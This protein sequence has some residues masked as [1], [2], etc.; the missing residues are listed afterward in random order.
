M[1]SVGLVLSTRLGSMPFRR[2]YG[3]DLWDKEFSDMLSANKADI[4]ASLRNAISKYEKRL[5]NLTVS[6]VGDDSTGP[7]VLGMQ[8]KVSGN[9]RDGEEE[10]KFEAH[11]DLG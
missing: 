6:F 9:Y 3:C 5:Y 7:H 1:Y 10:M 2:D 4:R 8:V 11:Y